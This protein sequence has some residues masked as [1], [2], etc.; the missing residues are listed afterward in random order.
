LPEGDSPATGIDRINDHW[1]YPAAEG[2]VLS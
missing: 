1:R 2:L